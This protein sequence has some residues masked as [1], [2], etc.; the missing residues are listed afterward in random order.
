MM[1]ISFFELDGHVCIV[2]PLLHRSLFE[3][4]VQSQPL[5][6]L[7]E[8]IRVI[9]KQLLAALDYMHGLGITHC[10]VKPDNILLIGEQSD[11]VSLIDFGSATLDH[12]QIGFYIQSRFYRSPEIILGLPYDSRID[13]WSAG[14]VAAEL[15]LDF[16]IFACETEFDANHSMLAILGPVPEYLLTRSQRWPRFFDMNREGFQAKANPL[17]VVM[18]RHCY[19]QFFEAVPSFQLEVLIHEHKRIET[20][21]QEAVVMCFCDFLRRLLVYDGNNRITAMQALAHP[22]MQGVAMP[23]MGW[24]PPIVVRLGEDDDV[25]NF[26]NMLGPRGV[27]STGELTNLEFLQ[28]M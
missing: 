27:S 12:S 7:L 9:M 6:S 15:F 17:E 8:T 20:E 10:D 5:M 28:M 3:G 2:M 4:I 25:P 23:A 26:R 24:T 11:A 16:A 13:V 19:R 21:E 1:P 22:F 18:T 14:C